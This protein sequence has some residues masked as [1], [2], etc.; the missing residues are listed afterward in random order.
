M[1]R[2]GWWRKDK[3]FD[4]ACPTG[5]ETAITLG[6]D[7]KSLVENSAFMYAI[8]RIESDILNAWKLSAPSDSAAREKLYYRME[9]LGH[10][11]MQLK[12]MISNMI[13][14]EQRA[15]KEASND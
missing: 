4:L 7:A 9:G 5:G 8:N 2:W 11:Q 13:I 3:P 10:I 12:G 1:V 6:K 15:N 14:E